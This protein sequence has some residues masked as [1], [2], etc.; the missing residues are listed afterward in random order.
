M[1]WGALTHFPC[2][3]RLEKNFHRSGGCRCTHCNPLTTPMSCSVHGQFSVLTH[4]CL[5]SFHVQRRRRLLQSVSARFHFRR[6][7]KA[8]IHQCS[9]RR[10]FSA[11]SVSSNTCDACR[12]VNTLVTS[13]M[14][15]EHAFWYCSESR[16][17]AETGRSRHTCFDK[18]LHTVFSLYLSSDG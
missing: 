11:G 12:R 3:L 5:R 16:E 14:Y 10:S 13:C 7:S 9:R 1:S 15:N 6:V 4:C 18:S 2:K 17:K 8:F